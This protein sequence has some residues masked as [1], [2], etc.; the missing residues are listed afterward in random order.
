[1]VRCIQ[2]DI[3]K[4]LHVRIFNLYIIKENISKNLCPPCSFILITAKPVLL[5]LAGIGHNGRLIHTQ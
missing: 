3:V 5:A 1:M 2:C 4:L